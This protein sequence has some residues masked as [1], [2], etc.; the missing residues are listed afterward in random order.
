MTPKFDF[1][2]VTLSEKY[3]TADRHTTGDIYVGPVCKDAAEVYIRVRHT[4]V[5]KLKCLR[6]SS[7]DLFLCKIQF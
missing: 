7:S 5:K 3:Q 6:I 1:E 4:L 2:K